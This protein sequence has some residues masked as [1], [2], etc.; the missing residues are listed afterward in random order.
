MKFK[1]YKDSTN[2]ARYYANKYGPKHKCNDCRFWGGTD[3]FMK[4][5][6]YCNYEHFTK[7]EG[8]EKLPDPDSLHNCTGFYPRFVI[9][10]DG[11][12]AIEL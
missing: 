10:G 4:F 12:D 9:W 5:N 7:E 8:S 1:D 2:V 6:T 3:N 11:E